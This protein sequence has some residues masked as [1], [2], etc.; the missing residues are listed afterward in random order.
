MCIFCD[1]VK[2][3]TLTFLPSIPWGLVLMF[4]V[5]YFFLH[6][7]LNLWGELLMFADRR[8]YSVSEPRNQFSYHNIM[9]IVQDWWTCS[10][11]KEFYKKWNRV[12]SDWIREYIYQ[13]FSAV[14]YTM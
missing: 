2:E 1:S 4:M 7:W 10:T 11:F 8:F 5:G 9:V 3:L 6:S 12:V 13:D 14:S